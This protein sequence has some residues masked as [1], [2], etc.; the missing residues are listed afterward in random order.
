[1]RRYHLDAFLNREARRV[2]VDHEG[3]ETLRARG[4]ARAHEDDIMVGDAAVRYPGL[5][6]VDA[7]GLRSVRC[8][9]GRHRGDVRAGL[10]LGQREGRDRDALTD[11][12]KV[13]PLQLLGSEQRDRRGAEPLHGEGEI[14]EAVEGGERLAGKA[15]R[16]H[17]ELR[18]ETAIGLGHH[19]T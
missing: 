3:R 15:Q 4:L 2:G 1:M 6:A 10:G 8:G 17:V 5:H 7:H 18:A 12:G 14:G 13:A 11:R 16:A 9:G 19:G